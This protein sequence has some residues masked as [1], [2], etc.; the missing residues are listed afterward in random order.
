MVDYDEV[1]IKANALGTQVAAAL[2]C[3]GSSNDKNCGVE[4]PFLSTL[5]HLQKEKDKLEII[6]WMLESFHDSPIIISYFL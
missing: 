1:L 6:V 4:L 5:Q 3:H 2:D